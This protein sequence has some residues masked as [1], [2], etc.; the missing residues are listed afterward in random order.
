MDDIFDL[1][2]EDVQLP[3]ANGQAGAGNAD[4]GVYDDTV[5]SDTSV[6]QG[7]RPERREPPYMKELN[8][9]QRQAVESTEG[10]VLVLSGAGTGKTRVLTTRIAYILHMGLARPWEVLAVT[11]TNKAAREMKERLEKNGR[12]GGLQRMAWHVSQHRRAHFGQVPRIG[13]V[14]AEFYRA[15]HG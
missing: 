4:A 15:G 11:F 7:L 3:L 6:K 10:P 5:T 14:K 1:D 9:E 8:P 13:R 2:E 12:V